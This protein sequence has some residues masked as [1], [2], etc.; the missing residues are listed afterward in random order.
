MVGLHFYDFW[1]RKAKERENLRVYT[2][3]K[4]SIFA[5][6]IQNCFNKLLFLKR[7]SVKNDE[8]D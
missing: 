5:E 6:K 7:K 1:Y 4:F 3:G 8:K 2:L